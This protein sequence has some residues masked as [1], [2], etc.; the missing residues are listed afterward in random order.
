VSIPPEC[1]RTES[2]LPVGS[3]RRWQGASSGRVGRHIPCCRAAY[4]L[5]PARRPR[6]LAARPPSARSPFCR[7]A[8]SGDPA[9]P[10]AQRLLI[11]HRRYPG[12]MRICRRQNLAPAIL[13][14][15]LENV[16]FRGAGGWRILGMRWGRRAC[17]YWEP[18]VS[19]RN[20]P[21]SSL[22][23]RASRKLTP[24]AGGRLIGALPE[25]GV[26]APRPS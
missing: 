6:L 5:H 20:E 15:R 12:A 1:A 9:A 19:A 22:G 25:I 26:L 16:S 18:T 13:A 24:G 3:L 11:Q 2:A 14:P 21:G 23:V 8:A 17:P 4:G 7:P 10:S